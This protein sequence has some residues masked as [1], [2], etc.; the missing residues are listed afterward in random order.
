MVKFVLNIIVQYQGSLQFSCVAFD[1]TDDKAILDPLFNGVD[2]TKW[3]LHV[4]VLT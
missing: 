2:E 1:T 4:R 3:W